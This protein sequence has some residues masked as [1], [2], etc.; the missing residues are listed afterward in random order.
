MKIFLCLI[1]LSIFASG[2]VGVAGT[3]GFWKPEPDG[4]T[5]VKQASFD[6]NR[7]VQKDEAAGSVAV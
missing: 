2:C 4:K 7:L 1:T 3:A 5:A 6:T